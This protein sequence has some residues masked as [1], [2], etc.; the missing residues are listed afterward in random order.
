[1]SK[2]SKRRPKFVSDEEF[3]T[4]WDRIYRKNKIQ[5]KTMEQTFE[6]ELEALINRYSEENTSDTPDYI[7]AH[8]ILKALEAF[9]STVNL[10]EQWYGREK[11]GSII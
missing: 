9:N 4:S 5:G 2:G 10:R 3:A 1:M 6:K 8:Y 11:I 7:L